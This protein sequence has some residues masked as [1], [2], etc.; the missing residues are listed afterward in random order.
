MEPYNKWLSSLRHNALEIHPRIN[1]ACVKGLFLLCCSVVFPSVPSPFYQKH[2]RVRKY[3]S[4]TAWLWQ[5]PLWSELPD[6]GVS[7]E[8]DTTAP[9]HSTEGRLSMTLVLQFRVGDESL[10]ATALTWA[11]LGLSALQKGPSKTDW[12]F[13]NISLTVLEKVSHIHFVY[14]LWGISLK[15]R[16]WFSGARSSLRFSILNKHPG[17]ADAAGPGTA[18]WVAKV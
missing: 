9:P 5:L 18:L 7:W 17:D 1:I 15:C 11:H 2:K 12:L 8:L 10:R 6:N 16:F 4:E 13:P 14:T 3:G